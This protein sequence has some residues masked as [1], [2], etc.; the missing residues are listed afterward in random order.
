MDDSNNLDPQQPA[1]PLQAPVSEVV[2]IQPVGFYKKP[3]VLF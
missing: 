1:V 2:E 3:A